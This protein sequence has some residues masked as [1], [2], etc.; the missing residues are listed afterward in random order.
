MPEK[1][2]N[3]FA[4]PGEKQY[5]LSLVM[6]DAAQAVPEGLN[7]ERFLALVRKD[8]LMPLVAARLRAMP[9]Q[10]LDRYPVFRQILAEQSSARVHVVEQLRLLAFLMRDFSGAGLRAL[11]LKGPM[12]AVKLYGDPAMRYSRD[13]DILVSEE[14]LPRACARLETMGFVETIDNFH[15][16][17]KRR[18]AQSHGGEEM[19]RVYALGGICVELHWRLTF[20]YAQSF[21]ELWARRSTR[22]LLGEEI[23][24][25]DPTDEL[26]Y[27]I[28]HGAGHGFSRLR[29]LVDLYERL[30][31]QDVD[32]ALLYDRMR[33]KGVEALL[34]ETLMLL[35]LVPGFRFPEVQLPL[36][37]MTLNGERLSLTYDH[38]CRESFRQAFRLLDALYPLLLIDGEAKGMTERRYMQLLPTV[39]RK[40][41]LLSYIWAAM[42]PC[43]ADLARFD[44]PDHL[45]FLYYIVRP[46]YKLWRMTPFYRRGQA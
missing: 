14:D 20:R 36:F 11:S 25:L 9:E 34:L 17:P 13:L 30:R 26:I 39:N 32:L 8:R 16:T 7:Q 35:Y 38:A 12:L 15:K 42:Q 23:F 4:L 3:R 41:T 10:T 5:L 33:E 6:G 22:K 45:Y 29:W 31:A 2:V 1:S 43:P 37:S 40:K 24:C 18:A 21:Q 44:F 19:H 28:C 27:L 46:F